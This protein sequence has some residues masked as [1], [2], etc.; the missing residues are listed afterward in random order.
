MSLLGVDYV[1][2]MLVHFPPLVGGCGGQNCKA[3][4]A[5]WRAVEEMYKNKTA[6]A[7]GVSNFCQSCFECLNATQTILPMVNQVAYHIGMG[8][9]P[10]GLFSYAKKLGVVMQAYSP[11]GNGS[12][13][14]IHG[15]LTTA[16]GAKY[17]KSSVQGFSSHTMSHL[18][19]N[20][21]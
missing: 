4:Q 10:E 2:L 18:P 21:C 5:Q 16:I 20:L 19:F 13:D 7:I 12:P 9:D 8:P 14:L 6:R 17:N 15:D 3:M 1:D 11:L